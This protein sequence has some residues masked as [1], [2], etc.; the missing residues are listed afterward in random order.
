MKQD[1]L[2]EKLKMTF[3]QD[4][5][6]DLLKK[7]FHDKQNSKT[8]NDIKKNGLN[9]NYLIAKYEKMRKTG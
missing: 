2:N 7:Y 5:P 3:K 6:L 8:V 1:E 4:D 9:A